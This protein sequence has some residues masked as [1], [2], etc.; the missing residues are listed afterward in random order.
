[1]IEELLKNLEYLN[2]NKAL[3]NSLDKDINDVFDKSLKDITDRW[4]KQYP[5]FKPFSGLVSIRINDKDFYLP[6]GNNK[7]DKNTIFDIASMSKAYTEVILFS[8]VDEYN[9]SLETKIKELTQLYS[10]DVAELTLMDLISFGN[11][12]LTQ[13]DMRNCTNREDAIKVLRTVYLDKTLSGIYKYTDIPLMILSD[14][15]ES[16]TGLSYK[17]L[18]NKYIIDKY[19]LK[20]TYLD[21]DSDNYVTINKNLTNDPKANI[22]GGYHGH[23]GVKTTGEE[24]N[25][26]LSH[27]LDNKYKDLLITPT[28]MKEKDGHLKMGKA[29]VGNFNLP[30]KKGD[31]LSSSYV[32]KEGFAIQGSVR[33]HGESC[34][35]YINGKE[36][37]V[38]S[39][40]FIDLYTQYKSIK[41]LERIN[42]KIYTRLYNVDDFGELIMC[43]VRDIIKYTAEYKEITNLVGIC[44]TIVLY[45]MLKEEGK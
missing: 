32:T 14:V 29:L 15:L 6:F 22:M 38:T 42:G 33:C 10:G 26:F 20:R 40:I 2:D 7:Y 35:F 43:D 9:I 19:N 11:E 34:N 3:L 4:I 30:T 41:E 45:K 1:M 13:G 36:Y 21:I 25:I 5:M 27:L 18:F 12:Y 23:C 37:R 39:S 17:E 16:Y 24:F 8:V 44:R 28:K 31:G